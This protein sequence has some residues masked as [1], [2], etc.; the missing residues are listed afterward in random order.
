[1]E[2]MCHGRHQSAV[3]GDSQHV[4]VAPNAVSVLE[5]E[6]RTCR[7]VRGTDLTSVAVIQLFC[8][9]NW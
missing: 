3:V 9:E 5:A 4:S 8:S 2:E 1:M 7:L 6:A